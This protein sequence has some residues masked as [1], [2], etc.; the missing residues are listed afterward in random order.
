MMTKMAFC[1]SIHLI[2]AILAAANLNAQV[3]VEGHLDL[4]FSY[5]TVAGEWVTQIRAG[6]FG[7]SQNF[8]LDEGDFACFR[9]SG[10][11][12]KSACNRRSIVLISRE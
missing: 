7:E 1:A 10:S 6:E 11:I 3:L 2:A 8:S 12:R 9:Y 5:S 4:S